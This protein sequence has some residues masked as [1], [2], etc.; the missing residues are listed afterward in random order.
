M[1]SSLPIYALA[2]HE[3]ILNKMALFRGVKPVYFDS[4]DSV[5]GKL[6]HDVVAILLEKGIL[7]KGDQ[8]IMTYGDEME[9]IGGTNASKI[10]IV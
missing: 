5:P 8:F 2:R 6:K 10:V 9:T 7:E 1:T 4:R 3:N